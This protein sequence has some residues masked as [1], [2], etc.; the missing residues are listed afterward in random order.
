[1]NDLHCVWIEYDHI[2]DP[3]CPVKWYADLHIFLFVALADDLDH[4]VGY[5]SDGFVGFSWFLAKDR[6]IRTFERTIRK[7]DVNIGNMKAIA[8]L[9]SFL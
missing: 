4:S 3:M 8:A 9:A 7:L 6:Y 2:F 5:L 1:M